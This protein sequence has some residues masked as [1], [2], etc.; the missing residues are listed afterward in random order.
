MQLLLVHGLG[1]TPLSLFG[2]GARLR[3]AGHRTRYFAY[4]P[5]FE[6]VSRIRRRL[7]ATLRELAARRKPVALIG[8][9]LGG[10]FLRMCLPDVPELRVHHLVTLGTPT[11]VPRM[12]ILAAKWFPPFRAYSR[13]CGQLLRSAE[14]LAAL[15]DISA[16]FTPIAGTA[17]PRSR[18][19][20]F[21]DEP[22][23]GVVAVCETRLPGREPEPFPVL[24]TFLMDDR[25]VRTRI[26]ELLAT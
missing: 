15:P 22:N 14:A 3:R 16:P 6:S 8:H 19:S 17:G 5:T 20:P 1:R 26:A 23:D 12:A 2:L 11:A 25:A 24:H 18:L 7:T 4:S 21:G 9:S 10:L 13:T